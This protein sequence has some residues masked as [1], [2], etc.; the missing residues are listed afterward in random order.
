MKSSDSYYDYLPDVCLIRT[1]LKIVCTNDWAV[2]AEGLVELV[3][4]NRSDAG[5]YKIQVEK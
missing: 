2:D 4:T 5:T 3:D 1:N